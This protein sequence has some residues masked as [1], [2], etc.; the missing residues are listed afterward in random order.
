MDKKSDDG[1]SA[2]PIIVIRKIRKG[3]HGGHGGAWKVA[4][5]DFVTSMM[6]F[7]LVMWLVGAGSKE[8][9]AAISQYFKN[10]S[11]VAGASAVPSPGIN[12]PG[13]ASDSMIKLGGTSTLPHGPGDRMLQHKS[14]TV[15]VKTAQQI[16]KAAEKK[17]LEKLLKQL[18]QAIRKSPFLK[19]FKKQLLLDITPEG[20]R[21]QIID[22]KNRPMFALG[23]ST[24]MP[25]TKTILQELAK[26]IN[27][28]P[29]RISINGHTDETPYVKGAKFS[30]WELSADRA[31]SARRALLAGSL[32]PR[33]IMRVVGYGATILF[34][35]KNPR[36]ADNRRISIIVLNNR[37]M[38]QILERQSGL[39]APVTPISQKVPGGV[40]T[41][42]VS[43][44]LGRGQAG[45]SLRYSGR[46]SPVSVTVGST[47][48]GKLPAPS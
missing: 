3:E 1:K 4:Y 26:I 17:R 29:N 12:G 35:P 30:N 44:A 25:Y 40:K 6:A 9:R 38:K 19:S 39:S 48:P 10:P 42:Q 41:V 22:N 18:K 43:N 27:T 16:S 31:N 13:G 37:T 24:L 36:D 5:A 47:M 46:V 34:D 20:L 32:N 14:S 23:S 21:I 11:M 28:V 2:A 15:N 7:F 33:R 45:K 8:Q